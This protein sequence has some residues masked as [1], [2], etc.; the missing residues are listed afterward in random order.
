MTNEK[1]VFKYN[2]SMKYSKGRNKFPRCQY[3]H[4]IEYSPLV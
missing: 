3:K 1:G 2:S 4:C